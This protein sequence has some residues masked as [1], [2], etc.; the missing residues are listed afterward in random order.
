MPF[1][2]TEFPGL[3]V[4]E[5]NVFEDSRGYFFESYN[6]KVFS[7]EGIEIFFIQ[8]NQASS[9]FGVIRG[10][11]YQMNPYAQTKLIRVLTGS[12][13]DVVVDIRYGSPTYGKAYA[14][15]L[16]A[17]NKKQLLVPKGFAH[18]Y[19]VTSDTAEVFYKCDEFYYKE[20]ERGI[21][22]QDKELNI[23]W[24]IPKEMTI[25]SDKDS[26]YLPF[27]EDQHHFIF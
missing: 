21:S 5:P 9:V 7:V 23:D 22:Y 2:K 27:D 1:V 26:V 3:I 24:K 12:I 19:S 25:I 17:A 6:K 14:I 16:S 11:H 20:Y 8:D 10:L 13:L 18:G 15:E 4:F